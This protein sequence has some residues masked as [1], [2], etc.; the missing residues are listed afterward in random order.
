MGT[1]L[2]KIEISQNCCVLQNFFAWTRCSS[3]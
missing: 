3:N 2:E 1:K